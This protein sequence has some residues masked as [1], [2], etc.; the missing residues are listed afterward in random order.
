MDL[1]PGKELPEQVQS[2]LLCL[3]IKYAWMV[4]ATSTL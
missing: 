2:G 1:N 3:F 4:C